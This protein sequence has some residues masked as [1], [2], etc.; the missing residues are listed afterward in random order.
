MDAAI[1]RIKVCLNGK[2]SRD[3][4]PAVPV[5]PAELAR[6]AAAAVAAGAEAVHLHARGADGAES[7]RAADVGAAVTAVR[8]ACPAT[9]IGVSTGVWITGGDPVARE[10]A[11]AGWAALAGPARPDFASLNVCEAGWADVARLLAASGIAVEAGVWS[12]ADVHAL[13]AGAAQAS[14]LRDGNGRPRP[15]LRIMVEVIGEPADRAVA[16]ADEIFRS[17][18]ASELSAVPRLLHGEKAGCWPLVAHAGQLGVPTRI[19][20]EDCAV[21]PDGDPVSGNAELVHLALA[22]LA[23]VSQEGGR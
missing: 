18:D 20:L 2:R 11:V 22:M 3:E 6:E 16:V 15:L 13:A 9:P 4:H 12:V 8:Q 5:T 1:K 10:R 14:L 17:L 21:G 23:T 19:G 7:L